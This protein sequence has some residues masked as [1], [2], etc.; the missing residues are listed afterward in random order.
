MEYKS[1]SYTRSSACLKYEWRKEY[2]LSTQ[3]TA[4]SNHHLSWN[5][6]HRGKNFILIHGVRIKLTCMCRDVLKIYPT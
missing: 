4:L 3:P 1:L 5:L 2:T 6:S